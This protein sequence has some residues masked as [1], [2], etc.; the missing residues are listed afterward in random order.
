M[1]LQP[2]QF[3]SNSNPTTLFSRKL[4]VD[5]ISVRHLRG[6]SLHSRTLSIVNLKV[7][8]PPSGTRDQFL[9]S[10][11][12]KLS[13]DSCGFV[14]MERPIWQEDGSIIYSCC[15]SS[16]VQFLLGPNSA[17]LVTK[18]YCLSFG[19]PPVWRARFPYLFP[20]EQDSTVLPPR[21]Q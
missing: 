5:K 10:S 8:R 18:C 15:W 14:I 11:S 4:I 21:V 6:L 19:T 16:P 9:F 3:S 13:L 1:W 20:Q 2:Q 17:G 12:L 7:I